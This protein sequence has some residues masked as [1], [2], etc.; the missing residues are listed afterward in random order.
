MNRP[1]V[2]CHMETS[3]D[4]KITGPFMN[5]GTGDDGW[6]YEEA[7]SKHG[8][9]RMQGWLSGRKT[10]E[11][12]FT[13]HRKPRLDPTASVPAGDYIADDTADKY[14]ISIDTHGVL[15]WERP[16]IDYGE[17]HAAVIEILTERTGAAYKAFLRSIGI[18]YLVA[19]EK[20]LDAPLALSKL[21]DLFG[22]ETIMLGGG[23]ILN[24]SFIK[25]GL[26]DELS[27][28]LAP[29]ADGSPDTPAVFQAV[30]GLSDTQPVSFTLT[31][32]EERKSTVWLRYRINS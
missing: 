23:G 26:C 4:G 6:F 8:H 30:P 15:G 22:M 12:N 13:D 32:V 2:F 10:T 16:T 25:Q 9:Y 21:K 7:F 3:L 17:T 27:L 31:S 11:E 24:W 28:M 1:Y 19:G 14:Y 5:I 20:E 18:S 29:A